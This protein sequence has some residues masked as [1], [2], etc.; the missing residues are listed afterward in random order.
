[1]VKFRRDVAW[2]FLKDS[3]V[4]DQVQ[5][6]LHRGDITEKDVHTYHM[7]WTWADH[8][9]AKQFRIVGW[10]DTMTGAGQYPQKNFTQTT[11][12][13]EQLRLILPPMEKALG[14]PE[15]LQNAK[16][17]TSKRLHVVEWTEEEKNLPL[18][19]QYD[20]PL[21]TTVNGSVLLKVA[22]SRKYVTTSGYK[23]LVS[24][25]PTP[26]R[27]APGVPGQSKA[28]RAPAAHDNARGD[29]VRDDHPSARDYDDYG[30]DHRIDKGDA[31]LQRAPSL[32][33]HDTRSRPFDRSHS[34]DSRAPSR[35]YQ[36]AD[37]YY[38]DSQYNGHYEDAGHADDYYL[39]PVA[40]RPRSPGFTQYQGHNTYFDAMGQARTYLPT[41]PRPTPSRE[42]WRPPP[43][44]P[45]RSRPPVPTH[46]RPAAPPLWN[47]H[48]SF[49][50]SS[51]PP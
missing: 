13:T 48:A 15:L 7:H 16:V 9:W 32:N 20:A 2:S 8:A 35:H 4:A 30:S 19:E 49:R 39:D 27:I 33:Y 18:P 37:D 6:L 3:L 1:M 36:D 40:S 5:I 34:P 10:L 50:D 14:C 21:V 24:I 25:G 12:S 28:V 11:F 45:M 46:S 47:D 44:V 42:D 38:L 23:P 51:P 43:P 17:D 22:D 31:H 26:P 41:R 29:R